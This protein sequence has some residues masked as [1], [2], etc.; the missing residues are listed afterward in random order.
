[1][2][3]RYPN[4]KESNVADTGSQRATGVIPGR[5]AGGFSLVELT[6]VLV[7][8]GISI[9]MAGGALSGFRQKTAA[10]HAAQLFVQDLSLARAHAVRG[11]EPVVIRFF[12]SG[13]WYTISSMTTGRE[14]IRRRFNVN[15]DIDLAGIDLQMP[16][17]SVFFTSRGILNDV[18]GQLGTATF[19]TGVAT[20]EVSFNIM[21]AS[22]VEKR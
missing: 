16:G 1:M 8:A 12:E 9:G 22:K 7:L 15:A 11:R 14:L 6:V 17:D 5:R 4:L 3:I 10:R 20:Y 18:G 19:S 21:G 13:R 2:F